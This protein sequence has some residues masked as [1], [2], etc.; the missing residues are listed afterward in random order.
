MGAVGSSRPAV[1]WSGSVTVSWILS[2]RRRSSVRCASKFIRWPT[3]LSLT[4]LLLLLIVVIAAALV[5]PLSF[6]IP[7]YFVH[8]VFVLKVGRQQ[9]R[10]TELVIK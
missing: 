5:V 7:H 2:P 4:L 1:K 10:E 8:V 6:V 3:V 9:G